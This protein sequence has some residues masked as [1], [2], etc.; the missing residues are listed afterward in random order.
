MLNRTGRI[1]A[2]RVDNRSTYN[3]KKKQKTLQIQ[4]DLEI[5]AV[6]PNAEQIQLTRSQAADESVQLVIR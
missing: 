2:T 3:I 1:S 4:N 6:E 5:H